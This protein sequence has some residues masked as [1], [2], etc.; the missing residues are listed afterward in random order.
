MIRN[1]NND[2]PSEGD[3]NV[4]DDLLPVS[5]S[6]SVNDAT[7]DYDRSHFQGHANAETM[8]QEQ[9]DDET[10]RG[11]WSLAKRG[12]GGFFYKGWFIISHRKNFRS[13]FFTTAF[14]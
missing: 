5:V 7:P 1:D 2:V 6:E 10:L 11:W 8:R 9:L 13:K 12:K 3:V 14:A 4:I